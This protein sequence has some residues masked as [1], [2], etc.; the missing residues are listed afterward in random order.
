MIASQTKYM[1]IG[2]GRIPKYE[3]LD[4]LPNTKVETITARIPEWFRTYKGKKIIKIYGTQLY[5]ILGN[6][7][8][9]EYQFDTTTPLEATIHSNIARD[10]NTGVLK[11]PFEDLPPNVVPDGVSPDHWEPSAPSSAGINDLYDNY[12]LT[13]NNFYTPKTYEYNDTTITEIKFWF[14][15]RYGVSIPIF[16]VYNYD[17]GFLSSF[18]L[19]KIEMELMTI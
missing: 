11:E 17:G 8:F 13:A 10:H 9:G 16:Y 14:K 12:V 1:V 4:T 3:M 6:E 19:F 18:L 5:Q 7:T 2:N 15:N